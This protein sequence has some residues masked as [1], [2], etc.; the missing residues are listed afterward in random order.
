M[1][2]EVAEIKAMIND[3]EYHYQSMGC[4]LEDRSITDRYEAM[5]YGWD[6][7]MER[8]LECFPEE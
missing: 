6:K 1:N 4:G 2:K 5:K 7:A 8:I 3:I